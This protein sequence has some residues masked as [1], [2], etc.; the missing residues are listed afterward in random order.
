[1]KRS[2]DELKEIVRTYIGDR[3]DDESI[4]LMEDLTDSLVLD[5]RTAEYEGRIAELEQKVIDTDSAWRKRYMD[6][7][8]GKIEEEEVE[9]KEDKDDREKITVEDILKEEE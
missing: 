2:I 9:E 4:S 5:D 7:F 1:M 6:R 3:T 8:N